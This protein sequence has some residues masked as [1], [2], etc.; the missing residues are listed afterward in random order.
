[1][2]PSCE[3][4]SESTGSTGLHSQRGRMEEQRC[5]LEPRRGSHQPSSLHHRMVANSQSR[6][7]DDQRV[8]LSVLPGL[9]VKK[10]K[11]KKQSV[12]LSVTSVML[13]V[14]PGVQTG[15]IERL[16]SSRHR[17]SGVPCV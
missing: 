1:F 8:S 7:L 4:Q 13:R 9:Q 10:K 2:F 15:G 3:K 14:C 6:R 12:W 16:G 17:H 5:S 11:K